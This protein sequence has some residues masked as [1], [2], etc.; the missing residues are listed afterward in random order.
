VA[1]PLAKLLRAPLAMLPGGHFTPL[2]CPEE[3]ALA[4]RGFLERLPPAV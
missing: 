3:V 4:L 2:D 1:R